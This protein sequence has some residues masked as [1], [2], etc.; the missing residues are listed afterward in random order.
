MAQ[1]NTPAF[2]DVLADVT[3]AGTIRVGIFED[4]P[5][6]AS[7]NTAMKIEGYDTEVADKRAAALGVKAELVAITGQ[8]R[9]PFLTKGKV[10][11]LL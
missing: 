8:N 9:I 10:D 6:V 7:L 4:F 1:N 11:V 2:A 3:A 5:P